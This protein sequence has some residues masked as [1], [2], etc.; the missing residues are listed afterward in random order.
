MII[1]PLAPSV[2]LGVSV[3]FFR[4]F[5]TGLLSCVMEETSSDFTASYCERC[6]A[7]TF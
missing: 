2:W 1:K 4:D 7:Q 6:A 3:E 5:S